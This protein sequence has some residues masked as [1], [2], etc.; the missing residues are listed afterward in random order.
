[1][2]SAAFGTRWILSVFIHS[3]LSSSFTLSSSSAYCS[4]SGK[5][6]MLKCVFSRHEY[7]VLFEMWA[8][9]GQAEGISD[10]S[11]ALCSSN[12]TQ[13]SIMAYVG[14][15]CKNEWIYVYMQRR[16]PRFNPWAEKIPWRRQ[17]Q[18]SPVFLP[19]ESHG[20]RSLVSYNPW[21]H[22]VKNDWSDWAQT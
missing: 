15:E 18:T 21:G 16:G 3:S 10:H 13:C 19:G 22:R 9:R 1:M 4:V 11:A 20:Q 6:S 14:K 5:H 12:S 2:W 8:D 17:W 7:S